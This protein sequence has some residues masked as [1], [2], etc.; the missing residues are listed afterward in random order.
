MAIP[1]A[2]HAADAERPPVRCGFLYNHEQLHQIAHSAPIA[3][4]LMRMGPA[5]EVSLI[6]TS[7]PQQRHLEALL[8]QAGLPTTGLRPIGLAPL[9]RVL[10]TLLDPFVPY[11]R[12]ATLL[13]NVETFRALDVL[14]VP[15][16]TSLLLR[17]RA[18]LERLQFVHTRHGAGDREVGFDRASGRFDF[19]LLSG[20]K[21]RDRLLA[22]GLLREDGHAIVGYPK[23]DLCPAGA[24]RPRLFDDDRPTVLYNPHCSPHLSSWFEH[25]LDVLEAFYRSGRYNLVFAPHVML[26]RKR[27][28]ISLAPP[29]LR[30]TGRIPARYRDCPH[31]HIDLGSERSSDMSYTEAADCYLGDVSSQIYEFLRRP[32]PCAFVPARPQEWRDDPNFRHWHCG[33]VLADPQRVIEGVDAAFATHDA[34]RAAQQALFAES[35]ALDAVPSSRRAAEAIVRFARR[36]S[37]AA[38]VA[39]GDACAAAARRPA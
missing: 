12:V 18:G 6:T 10:A 5:L 2:A 25:G 23:F 29:A 16:K 7:A 14:V 35:I 21:I 31:I 11:S 39:A 26:F 3:F 34:Y 15:E 17:T 33:P 30:R 1:P 4:E 36:G 19:V 24:A 13:A 22:A 27:V 8:R 28:Q 38:A 9:Q 20:P 32:R 37:E